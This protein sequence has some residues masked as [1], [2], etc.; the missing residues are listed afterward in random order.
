MKASRRKLLAGLAVLAVAPIHGTYNWWRYVRH[1][2]PR[3]I[4]RAILARH[5][6]R[7]RIEGDA[8]DRF[9]DDYATF[10]LRDGFPRRVVWAGTVSW[11]HRYAGLLTDVLGDRFRLFEDDTVTAFLL[12]TDFFNNGANV[13]APVRYHGLFNPE[14]T[15]CAMRVFAELPD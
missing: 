11:V 1:D 7:L 12:S 15:P 6:A 9:A 10:L 14:R 2:D 8:F 5:L 3:P 4:I 13:G